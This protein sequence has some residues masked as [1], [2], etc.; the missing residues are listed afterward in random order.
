M[1]E[2]RLAAWSRQELTYASLDHVMGLSMSF[3]DQKDSG[4]VIK[5]IEQA[6]SLNEL[7]RLL[8]VDLSPA[9]LDVV[10]SLWYV[11]YLLDVYAS[12]I[13]VGMII[14]FIY[15]ITFPFWQLPKT[16]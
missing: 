9:G 13:V 14:S 5:A 10:I 4:E 8:I 16:S 12:F 2:N 11:T 7:L 1:L 15:T 3:H 6:E